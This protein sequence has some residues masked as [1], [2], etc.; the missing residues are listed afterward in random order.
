MYQRLDTMRKN[1]FASVNLFGEDNNSSISGVWIWRGQ[2]LAF[3]QS[4]EWQTDYETYE[5]KKLDPNDPETK[6]LVKDY[7]SWEGTDSKGRKFNQGKVFK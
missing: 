2:D 6:K 7:W 5:W 1:S 3:P 4:P